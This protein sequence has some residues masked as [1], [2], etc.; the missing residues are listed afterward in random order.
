MGHE[1]ELS[2][3]LGL[4]PWIIVAYSA[5]FTIATAVFLIYPIVG[6]NLAISTSE[7]AKVSH[8]HHRIAE[9]RK[10]SSRVEPISV[11]LSVCGTSTVDLLIGMKK[12]PS[13]NQ[14]SEE[15]VVENGWSGAIK[16]SQIAITT[17]TVASRAATVRRSAQ[18]TT[19]GHALSN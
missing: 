17:A 7:R 2:F 14:V 19:P 12:T 6:P 5:P 13:V 8:L 3:H 10:E 16:R 11:D 9:V 1:W 15:S 4:R 18:E